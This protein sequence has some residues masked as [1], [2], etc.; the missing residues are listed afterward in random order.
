M[1]NEEGRKHWDEMGRIQRKETL[2]SRVSE[3]LRR[4]MGVKRDGGFKF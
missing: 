3:A 1:E 2:D 4:R